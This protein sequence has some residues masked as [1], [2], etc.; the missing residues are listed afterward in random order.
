MSRRSRSQAIRAKQKA[1]NQAAQQRQQ[2]LRR[3]AIS[4][5][6][7]ARASEALTRANVPQPHRIVFGDAL[8]IP[9]VGVEMSIF[10]K[11][12]APAA[13]E[14]PP[15]PNPHEDQY[16]VKDW[17]YG[18]MGGGRITYREMHCCGVKELHG[19]QYFHRYSRRDGHEIAAIPV[20]V[21]DFLPTALKFIKEMD[22]HRPFWIYTVAGDPKAVDIGDRLKAVIE[23]N[24]LGTVAVSAPEHNY[25]S[26]NLVRV[27]VWTVPAAV[28]KF[29]KEIDYGVAA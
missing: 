5:R 18:G 21:E 14:G 10:G 12:V 26:G 4:P 3:V 23:K 6:D 9:H 16:P 8:V 20:S 17:V 27:Y 28:R 15:K 22:R 7:F 19:L 13:P 11:K 1:A 2:S 25:N 29:Q 24:G